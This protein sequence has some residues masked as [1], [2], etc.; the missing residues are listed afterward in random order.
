[1]STWLDDG[2]AYQTEMVTQVHWHLVNMLNAATATLIRHG[3]TPPDL[4]PLDPPPGDLDPTLWFAVYFET[5]SDGV[6]EFLT[7]ESPDDAK[8]ARKI[9]FALS[10]CA[11]VLS[12]SPSRITDVC[13]MGFWMNGATARHMAL[14]RGATGEAA[15]T[16]EQLNVIA[17]Q[18]AQ[19]KQ[20][21]AAVARA[22]NQKR[23]EWRQPALERAK[24]LCALQPRRPSSWIAD[25]IWQD[26]N[27]LTPSHDQVLKVVR[28]WRAEGQLPARRA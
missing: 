8:E 9:I 17:E 21:R 3:W 4:P 5:V 10:R 14:H 7:D 28:R 23:T 16:I 1:M 6:T 12:R 25:Q 24:A 22:T 2:E 18:V 19:Q 20:Q 11:A 26:Q 15:K 27:I 13:E